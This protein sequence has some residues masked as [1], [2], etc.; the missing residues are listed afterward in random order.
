MVSHVAE[1]REKSGLTQ[2]ELA[3]LVG[4]TVITISNWERNRTGVEQLVRVAKLCKAL[5]CSPEQLATEE[6]VEADG[7]K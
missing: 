3:D 7:D 6:E 1:L 2:K 4:T 5:G